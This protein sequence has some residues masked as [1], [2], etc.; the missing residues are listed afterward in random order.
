MDSPLPFAFVGAL[1]ASIGAC[2]AAAHPALR[3]HLLGLVSRI[4]GLRGRAEML[5]QVLAH[6]ARLLAPRVLAPALFWSTLGWFAECLGLHLVLV[7][8]G[9][10]ISWID[11]TWVYA[12]A[13]ALGNLTF[14]PG[15]LGSTEATMV[16]LLRTL[17][18]PMQP[19]VAATL[20]VRAATLW[21]A[22]FLGLLVTW[23]GR[24]QL[25]WAEVRRET[26]TLDDT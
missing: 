16:G 14:L 4:P 25:Q 20:L 6:N 2:A 8:L 17:D 12:V 10:P 21:F 22:V 26:A 18:V 24:K 9:T 23:A 5:E 11:A 13:T 3:R 15:G 7:G 19:A 1:I